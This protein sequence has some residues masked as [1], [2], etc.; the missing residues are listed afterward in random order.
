V[1]PKISKLR[2]EIA[3]LQSKLVAVE[4]AGAP[5]AHS[6]KLLA[7]QMDALA[8]EYRQVIA[9][10]ARDCLAARVDRDLSLRS[11]FGLTLGNPGEFLAGALVAHLGD[12][13]LEDVRSEVEFIS[14]VYP[15]ALA[16]GERDAEL[17]R[18]RRELRSLGRQEEA[19]IEAEELAGNFVERRL[20]ADPVCVL[21]IPDSF[22]EEFGL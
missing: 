16:D 18:L 3:A 20:D 6:Q 13:I 19:L 1:N 7:G 17:V 12:K 5:A 8:V 14:P 2:D 4:S 21:Q 22:C 11:R 10:L 9:G 15:A